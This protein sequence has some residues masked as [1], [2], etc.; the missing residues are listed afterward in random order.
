MKNKEIILGVSTSGRNYPEFEKRSEVLEIKG[1]HKPEMASLTLSS[2]NFNRTASMNSPQMIQAL[3]KKMNSYNIKPEL[4]VFDLGMI[5]YAKY[6]EQ[7]GLLEPPHYFNLI[8]GNIACAQAD[9]LH[10][11]DQQ[12]KASP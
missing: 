6:L 3:V 9:L 5:N 2:L 1:P 12:D 7:K 11:T 8:V 4:E 10:V